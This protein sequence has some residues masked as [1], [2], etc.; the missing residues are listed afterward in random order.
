MKS[1]VLSMMETT[2]P[3]D[4]GSRGEAGELLAA[5]NAAREG[6]WSNTPKEWKVFLAWGIWVLVFVPPFDFL[7]GNAWWPVVWIA[8]AVG[9]VATTAYFVSRSRRLHWVRQSSWRDWLVIFILYGLIMATAAIVQ[10]QFRYA[11]TTAALVAAL[12]Y[13]IAALVIRNRER[14]HVAP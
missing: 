14:G 1:K 7:S 2:S 9:G 13:F 8:S 4:P 3:A 12:P 5:A 10:S 11:W 6:I